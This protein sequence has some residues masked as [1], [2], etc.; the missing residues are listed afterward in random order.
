M[1]A[2]QIGGIATLLDIDFENA[3]GFEGVV[4]DTMEAQ[5]IVH[6]MSHAL[7]FCVGTLIEAHV[8][9]TPAVCV[10]GELR[11]FPVFAGTHKFIGNSGSSRQAEHICIHKGFNQT[12]RWSECAEANL[13]LIVLNSQYSFNTREPKTQFIIRRLRYGISP[14]VRRNEEIMHCHYYGWGSRRNGYLLPL[15]IDLR[16]VTVTILPADQCY[17]PWKHKENFLCIQQKLCKSEKYG[18]LCPD[19]IGTVIECS[20]YA[21]GMMI[22][23]L[24][25]RPCGVGYLDLTKHAKFLTCGVDD[26]RDVVDHDPF[27][28]FDETTDMPT[29]APITSTSARI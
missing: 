18:A 12:T 16:K 26:A 15:S 22:S 28:H 4:A 14:Q 19:D 10:H 7:L 25:D 21:V 11:K 8:V 29:A 23:R 6:F 27:M 24:I 17:M 9:L 5:Y 13:A 2:G 3:A 1:G 20:G